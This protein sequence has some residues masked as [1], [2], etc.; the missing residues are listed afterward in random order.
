MLTLLP[1]LTSKVTQLPTG[2]W[3]VSKAGSMEAKAGAAGN[4]PPAPMHPQVSQLRAEP[5]SL[6]MWV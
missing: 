6:A 2:K 4:R 5:S 1:V 3:R